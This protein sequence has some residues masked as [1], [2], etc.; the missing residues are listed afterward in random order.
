MA[1][2]P[3]IVEAGRAL[4]GPH[5]VRPLADAL[6]VSERTVRYWQDGTR[7]PPAGIW[8]DALR[9]ISEKEAD[10]K[11]LKPLLRSPTVR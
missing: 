4:F 10:L 6:Q 11:A 9:L 3:L 2:T 1:D 7:E 5:W 8:A